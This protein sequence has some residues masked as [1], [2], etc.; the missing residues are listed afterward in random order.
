MSE[1]ITQHMPDG[2]SF[3]ER[4]FA[5]F[6]ALE[7]HLNSRIDG[8]DARIDGLD[9]RLTSLEEK[10]DLRLKETRPIWEQVLV[11]LDSLEKGFRG[12]AKDVDYLKRKFRIFNEDILTW[13]NKQ[14][15]MEERVSKL[16]SE[17]AK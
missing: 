13:Q 2:R 5:R 7:A 10:V 6:D 17:S 3:E 16:E 8:L 12:I 4:V 14:D 11:R 1:D 9:A 15:D